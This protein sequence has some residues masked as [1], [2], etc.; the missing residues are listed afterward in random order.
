MLAN[1]CEFA[2]LLNFHRLKPFLLFGVST[3]LNLGRVSHGD[4]VSGDKEAAKQME[5]QTEPR[6][7]RVQC[8]HDDG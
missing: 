3:S 2:D 8:V 6:L 5:A 4:R 1:P 7:R